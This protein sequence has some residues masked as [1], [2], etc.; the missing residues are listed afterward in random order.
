MHTYPP[1]A[2]REGVSRIETVARSRRVGRD[3]RREHVAL[4]RVEGPDGRQVD[5]AQAES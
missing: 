2:R 4:D 1:R 3:L 5:L